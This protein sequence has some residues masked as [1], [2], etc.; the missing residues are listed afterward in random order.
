MSTATQEY[1]ADIVSVLD[2]IEKW[3]V[4]QLKEFKTAYEERF[5]V[6][7]AAAMPMMMAGP[8][9]GADVAAPVAKTTF[10]V[11][12]KAVGDKKIQVIK[13]VRE[14]TGLG[15]KEAKQLVDDSAVAPKAVKENLTKDEAEELKKKLEESGAT[16][17]LK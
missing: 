7:A 10:D 15:L 9:A 13:V 16:I 17:E 3:T 14:A 5:D 2:K 12:L 1:S 4:L 11:V 6:T 8:A